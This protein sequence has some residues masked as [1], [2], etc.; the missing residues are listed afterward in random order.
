VCLKAKATQAGCSY[1][2][3]AE[4]ARSMRKQRH[5]NWHPTDQGWLFFFAN[6]ALNFDAV[7][8]VHMFCSPWL[9]E[10]K[11]QDRPVWQ[12]AKTQRPFDREIS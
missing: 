5:W 6:G 3:F 4:M 1:W 7:A 12:P 8:R 11:V 10:Q 2:P 9:P